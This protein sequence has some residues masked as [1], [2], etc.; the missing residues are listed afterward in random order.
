[1]H[2][3]GFALARESGSCRRPARKAKTHLVPARFRP[4]FVIHV[5]PKT[6]RQ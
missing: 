4:P 1:M 5:G 2:A 6:V 3:K